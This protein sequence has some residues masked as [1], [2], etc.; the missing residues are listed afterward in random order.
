[1]TRTQGHVPKRPLWREVS[2]QIET[3]I[4]SGD[5]YPGERLPT[6]KELSA[7]YSAH[8][9]TVRRALQRLKEKNLVRIEQGRGMFVRETAITH[10]IGPHAK[11]SVTASTAGREASR[12]FLEAE[13][14]RAE[15]S[16]CS[17]L[18]LVSG[19]MVCRVETLR[20]VDGHPVGVTSHYFPLPR[21][22][23]IDVKVAEH[24]SVTRALQ[25][26]SIT[27][28]AHRTSRIA[29]RLPNASDAVLLCQPKSKPILF[30]TTV[31]IDECRKTIYMM[32][33]RFSGHWVELTMQHA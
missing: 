11:L 22:E 28:F 26:Y 1:M 20:L 32:Y 16:V 31:A 12:Q 18:G 17:T 33:T 7:T 30:V 24:G 10:T 6:E 5:Y 15:R 25:D 14:C 4:R 19:A 8:R 3:A 21:F 2:D 29:A 27:S 23:G 9:L 13:L